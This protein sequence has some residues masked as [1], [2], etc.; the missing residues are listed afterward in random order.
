MPSYFTQVTLWPSNNLLADAS[1]NTWAVDADDVTALGLFHDELETFYTSIQ[2]QYPSL[3][4]QTDHEI[5]SYNRADPTPRAPVLSTKFDFVGSPTGDSLPPEC[6][7]C[8]SFQGN[9][10]SGSNQARR[11]GRVFIGPLRESTLHTD[12]RPTAATVTALKNAGQTLLTNSNSAT[13]W[14]WQVWST[15]GNGDT[16]I[17]NGWVDNEYDTQRR[18]G[19]VATSRTTFT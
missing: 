14:K 10:M 11:R 17:T 7:M 4:R 15:A 5:V 16:Q 6:A 3:V 12:G 9:P 18:R 2:G 8:V 13:T 19:R 1:T